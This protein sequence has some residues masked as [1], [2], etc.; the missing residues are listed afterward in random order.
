MRSPKSNDVLFTRAEIDAICAR[1]HFGEKRPVECGGDLEIADART[2]CNSLQGTAAYDGCLF[3]L[4]ASGGDAK[5]VKDAN[6][7]FQG[8]CR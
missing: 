1:C 6:N 4:C 3:D 5:V 7:K 2:A 8:D